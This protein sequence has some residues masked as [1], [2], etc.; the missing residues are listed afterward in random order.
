MV[1][2]TPASLERDL[3]SKRRVAAHILTVVSPVLA[4]SQLL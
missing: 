4:I 1:I 2:M 3:L